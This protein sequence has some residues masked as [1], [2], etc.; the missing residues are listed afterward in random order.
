[1]DINELWVW[2]FGGA[3]VVLT[4]GSIL[5]SCLCT[6]LPIAGVGW[7]L[8]SRRKQ[9]MAAQQASQGWLPTTG[10]VIKSRVEVSG[11]EVTSVTPRVI[12]TYQVGAVEYQN[13]QIRAGDRFWSTR[14][15]QDAYQTIDRY[16]EGMQVTVFYNPANPAESAL[17]R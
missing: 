4:I 1:M 8:Y 12:Y 7:F 2:L 15:S 13:D 6:L 16:P 9:G 10:T 11:G 17:E 14:S 3:T 5:V